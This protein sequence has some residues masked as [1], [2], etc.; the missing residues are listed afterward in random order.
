MRAT[1]W[2]LIVVAMACASG[3][4][5][6]ELILS[7][8]SAAAADIGNGVWYQG[9]I[10]AINGD[11]V[12]FTTKDGRKLSLPFGKALPFS[13]AL[14]VKTGD[15]VIAIW[16]E[17]ALMYGAVVKK[18]DK[19]GAL[20]AWDDGTTASFVASDKM[21]RAAD[22][23]QAKA[24]KAAASA[25]P[26]TPAAGAAA[27][28]SAAQ[29]ADKS[30]SPAASTGAAADLA[31]G[32]RVAGLLPDGNWYIGDIRSI[33]GTKYHFRAVNG[34]V[35]DVDRSGIRTLSSSLTL[36]VGERVM[37]LW[38]DDPKFYPGTIKS[39]SGGKAVIVWDDG[40]DPSAVEFEKI[41]KDIGSYV[42]VAVEEAAPTLVH[43]WINGT[44]FA[45][46]DRET[47]RIWVGPSVAA[48]KLSDGRISVYGG[49]IETDGKIYKGGV[50]SGSIEKDGRL[51]RGGTSIGSIESNGTIYCKGS[52]IGSI[53]GGTPDWDTI[54]QVAA[55]L[56]FF[57][58]DFGY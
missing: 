3:A 32:A 25:T 36:A 39:V 4:I 49:S 57:V 20:V 52:T 53:D 2:F 42:P 58:K 47:G 51:W 34:K 15:K 7:T 38:Y 22:I 50:S 10:T 35:A 48:E 43:V 6:Q 16:K 18:T 33:S 1:K 40:S 44:I 8:G 19:G 27:S 41:V 54:R 24:G 13:S 45:E 46:A 5:A 31:V 17:D 23:G 29:A 26:A 30:G 28:K 12:Q 11:V 55:V 9:K 14:V 56:V 21:V 37:A